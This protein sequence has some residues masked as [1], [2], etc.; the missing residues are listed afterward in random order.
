MR[1]RLEEL[2]GKDKRAAWLL[3]GVGLLGMLLLAFPGNQKRAKETVQPQ[4]TAQEGDIQELEK[5]L[6]ELVSR[7]EGAGETTV[8]LTF[9]GSQEK[10][11]AMDTDSSQTGSRQ[12]HVLL[13]GKEPLV[14]MVWYPEVQGVAILCEGADNTIVRAQITEI[15][16]VLLGVSSNRVSIAK[17]AK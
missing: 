2:L 6:Q 11:Y 1:T 4:I 7:V 10:V 13:E 5:R 16:S 14:D 8:M 17:I 3:A 12:E 15:A 9:E